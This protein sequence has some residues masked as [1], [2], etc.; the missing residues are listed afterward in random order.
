[1]II[2]WLKIDKLK[3]IDFFNNITK[4]DKQ[5]I[6][7][8][9]NPEIL[10]STLKD[11]EY[12]EILN[13]AD[14]LTPDGKGL[15]IAFQILS[16]RTNKYIKIFF[17]PYFFFNFFFRTNYLYEKFWDR[18]CWSD[19]TLDLIDFSIRNNIKIAIIDLYSEYSKENLKKIESQKNFKYILNQKYKNLLFDY[20]I[21]NPL[22]KEEIIEKIK[23][24][25]A[26]ILFSTLGMK[27]QEESIIEVMN[28]AKNIKLWLWI[29]SSFDYIIW[30]QKRAPKFF[31]IIWIEWFYRLLT[32]T[33]KINRF[34]R[35]YNAIF[36]FIFYVLFF[37]Y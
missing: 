20:Y 13:K 11:L 23:K 24:S 37:N 27:K 26:L 22:E 31:R 36:L 32:W 35:L 9:P 3:Y 15:Y 30:F 16:N 6:V 5:K 8:T 29:W 34:K 2:F 7:F 21:Y 1:M 28:Q 4:F 33:K 25:D 12:K 14:Y 18:I 17:L 10:L 19:L